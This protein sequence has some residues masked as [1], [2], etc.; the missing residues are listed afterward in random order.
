MLRPLVLSRLGYCEDSQVITDAKMRFKD[1]I[2]RHKPIPPDLRGTVFALTCRFGADE[3]LTQM[4]KLYESSDSSEI[5]RQCLQAI[6]RC[7]HT[8]VQNHALEFAISKNCRLQ[9][10]YLVFYGLTRTLAGQE[11]AWK[12]FRNN[13]NLLC[14]LFGSQDNGLFIHILKMSI[15]H[16][17]SEEKAEDIQNFFEHRTVSPALTRPISQSLENINLNIKFLRNNASAIGAWLKEEGY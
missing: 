16:H 15:M 11:K 3:E 14:D 2:L 9:D 6:G 4:R 5:Q 10:N 12:F 1:F 7:P 13:M 8:D 17:C